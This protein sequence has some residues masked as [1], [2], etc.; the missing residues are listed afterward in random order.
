MTREYTFSTVVMAYMYI[1][2]GSFAALNVAVYAPGDLFH[3][4]DC[5]R[6]S[7][8]VEHLDRDI[9]VLN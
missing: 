1:P 3:L 5:D 9:V 4:Q 6:P 8:H 2:V 7:E